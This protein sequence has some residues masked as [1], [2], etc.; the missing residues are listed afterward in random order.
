M[1]DM[2]AVILAAGEG[3]RMQSGSAKALCQV[4]FRPM[5]DWVLDNCRQAGISRTCV[6]VGKSAEAVRA[7]LDPSVE[8]ALQAERKGTGHAALCAADF[9][10][11]LGEGDVFVTLGDAPFLFPDVISAAHELHLRERNDMTV[12]TA[13]LEDPTG[14]GRIIRQGNAVEAIVEQRDAD[15]AQQAVDE[16][17]SG[18]FWFRAPALLEALRQLTPA[19]SQGEYYLTDTLKV[20]REAGKKVGAF[21]SENNLCALGANTRREL[22]ALNRI[23]REQVLDALYDSG[24]DIPFP[25]GVAVDA[26]AS[27]APGATILPGTLIKGRCIIGRGCV[28]GPNSVLENAVLG[29]NCI[30][31]S[32]YI[33]DSVLGSGVTVGPFS[34]IRPGCRIADRVKIGDFVEVKNSVLGEKTSAAHLTYIGDTDCGA[35]VNFGCGVVTVNYNGREKFRTTI[36]D[37]CFVGCNTNLIAPVTLGDGAYTAAGSTVTKDVPPDALCIARVREENILP[38]RAAAYR[39]DKK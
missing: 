32:S 11:S 21:R 3:K 27:V 10:R 28:I 29:E 12:I 39:K 25:D 8:T 19:N 36:G 17:N 9:L 4:L 33:T 22:A 1:S 7:I 20:L 37:G 24:V 14:Y 13:V 6:V 35:G 30:I 18:A 5:L 38:G 26:R 16:I 23:A 34:Q 15:E 31:N 2:A